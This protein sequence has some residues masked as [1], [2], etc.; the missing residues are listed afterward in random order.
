MEVFMGNLPADLSETRL[1]KVMTPLMMELNITDWMCQKQ[2]KKKFGTVAFLRVQDGEKFLRQHGEQSTGLLN[3]RGQ[4]RMRARLV[5]LGSQQIFCKRS[6]R[7]IDNFLLKALSKQA[8][9]RPNEEQ[10]P[11]EAKHQDVVFDTYQ[12]SCGYYDYDQARE[13][14]FCPE[15]DWSLVQ[16]ISKFTPDKII[17]TFQAMD[18]NIRIEIPYRIIAAILTCSNPTSATLTLWEPPRLFSTAKSDIGSILANLSI[19][20]SGPPEPTR[21]RLTELPHDTKKHSE[22][23]GQCLIYRLHL[24][25]VD[26]QKKVNK[27]REKDVLPISSHGFPA[28]TLANPGFPEGLKAF[29][30]TVS[31]LL[32]PLQFGILFQV[33]ALVQNG[34]LLPWKGKDLLLRLYTASKVG[35][36]SGSVGRCNGSSKVVLVSPLAIKKLFS[37]IPFPAP[38]I[39]ASTF[40]VDEIVRYIEA[41]EKEIQL[42]LTKELVSEKARNNLTMVYKVQVTPTSVTLHGPEAEAKNRILRRFHDHTDCF[43]R[44]QFCDEDGQDVFFNPRLS[45]DA[46]YQ[47][48]LDILNKGILIGGRKFDFL[49]FSH[50]SLRSHAVWFMAPFYNSSGFH[51]YFSVIKNLGDFGN[52]YS[53]ARCAARIGQAFSETPFAIPL[54]ENRIKPCIIEDIWSKDKKRRFTD[55]VGIISQE[56]VDVIQTA[57]PQRKDATCYQIRWAGAKGMLALDASLDGRIMAV[58]QSMVKFESQ[59]KANLEICDQ[60]SKPIPLVLNRQMIKILEDMAVP[61]EWFLGEQDKELNRLRRITSTTY[62]TTAFLK[63]QKVADQ[64]GLPRLLR[65]LELIGLDYKKDRFLC[66]V[67]EAVVLRELRLLKHKARIP[68]ETGVTLFGIVDETGFLEEGEVYIT[69]EKTDVVQTDYLLFDEREMIVTRSPALHPGDIQ[70]ATNR[71]PPTSHPLRFLRNCIVFSQKGTRDLPSQLSGGDLDGDIYN[72]I[73][74]SF[75]VGKCKRV[76]VPAD[77]PLV[78]P[79]TLNRRVE[80]EDMTAFFVEFM[81][82]DN[83]GLIA[84]KHM[85]LADQKDAGTVDQGCQL[86]AKLHSTG[87]DYSKTGV[88]VSLETLRAIKTNRYRPDFLAPAPPTHLQNRSEIIFEAPTGPAADEDDEED[89]RPRYQYYRSE[90]ILGQLF[91]AIDEKKIWNENV[92]IKHRKG[93]QGELWTG[94]MSYVTEQCEQKIG[95][96]AW[97]R[98]V[99]EAWNIRHAYEDAI[100][101]ACVEY[102]EHASKTI[103][104]LEVFTGNIFNKLGVQTRRQRDRSS[105]LKDEFAR[106][107]QWIKALITKRAMAEVRVDDEDQDYDVG[108]E[109]HGGASASTAL[110]LSIACLHVGCVQEQG[111]QSNSWDRSS[112]GGDYQSF[113]ALA[114]CCLVKE[115]DLATKQAEIRKGTAIVAGGYV[116]VSSGHT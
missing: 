110:E 29:N 99:D 10:R 7:E 97:T 74:D 65:R 9:D 88:P 116:G 93:A 51:T 66:S 44:V 2:R 86:L 109:E 61:A 111:K 96:I 114:A 27:L 50:S 63:R 108:A 4:P 62:N 12:L 60:A 34:Y 72:I 11:N 40:D 5:I 23:I 82:T 17:V 41:N 26:F 49:G 16:G 71:V 67:V 79:R 35:K 59:D 106:I 24:Y 70:M 28:S 46:V 58:R 39:D 83:L 90:K 103:T 69:F 1:T 22:I 55:G 47:R 112:H 32:D 31:E 95:D 21:E 100:T 104:E 81:K 37:Q 56:I 15:I 20:A 18:D 68:I 6:N 45:Y 42:N 98:C 19:S 54:E 92:Q 8:E 33:Q 105:Q 75:A 89:S 94:F 101:A 91:R 52:I 85:I 64:V 53:P 36:P 14:A 87:V 115:L 38:D 84:V 80:R 73:W 13:L 48:F 30:Q 25:P 57:M 76:F 3:H 102:S 113:K 107:A 77:Y 43:T 78:E